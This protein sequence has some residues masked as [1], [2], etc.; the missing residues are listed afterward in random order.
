MRKYLLDV[1]NVVITCGYKLH[2]WLQ[3]ASAADAIRVLFAFDYT[4][5]GP[6]DAGGDQRRRHSLQSVGS[7]KV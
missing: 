4:V 2:L 6:I 5:I 7:G 3:T 1:L